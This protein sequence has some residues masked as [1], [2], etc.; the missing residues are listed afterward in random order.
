MNKA[1]LLLLLGGYCSLAQAQSA[2]TI[3]D[4]M[5]RA[6]ENHPRVSFNMLGKERFG[7]EYIVRRSKFHVSESPRKVYF[8]DL[9]EGV[10]VLYVKGWNDGDALVNPNGF[11]W[12]NVNL[13]PRGSR[14]R[15]D[16]HHTVLSAGFGYTAQLMKSIEADL[17]RQGRRFEDYFS[18]SSSSVT[19]DGRSCYKLYINYEDYGYKYYTVP[20]NSDLAS[21]CKSQNVPEY[22]VKELNNLDFDERIAAGTK[23]KIPNAYAK[24]VIFY[25]DKSSYFPVVQLIYDDKGLYEKYEYHNLNINPNFPSCEWTSDCSSY[26]F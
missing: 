21:V 7:S 6:I 14:M 13:S 11:P 26:G 15:N 24:R 19:F 12:V 10:E 18:V 8:K 23:L 9:D 5:Y 25:V 4:R 17:K 20:R 22:R 3:V 16:Q 1:L 2:R